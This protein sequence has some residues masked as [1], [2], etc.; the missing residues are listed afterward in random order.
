MNALITQL[1]LPRRL[2]SLKLSAYVVCRETLL[3]NCY[4]SLPLLQDER[5]FAN[6]QSELIQHWKIRF[7]NVN[8]QK[9][10]TTV[11]NSV[12]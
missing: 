3:V 4:V 10:N 12:I 7:K 1:T 11:E 8:F 9:L 6:A 2:A 5:S